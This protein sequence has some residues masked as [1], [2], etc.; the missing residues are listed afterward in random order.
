[1]DRGSSGHIFEPRYKALCT[2]ELLGQIFKMIRHL[3]G[4]GD[5]FLL[6]YKSGSFS[7]PIL[8]NRA[9]R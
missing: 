3:C 7:S 9:N 5:A 1:M 4:R 2:Q 6:F 8:T